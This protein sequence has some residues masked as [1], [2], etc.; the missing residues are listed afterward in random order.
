MK[1]KIQFVE[2]LGNNSINAKTPQS[3]NCITALLKVLSALL[4]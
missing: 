4:K 3:S 1:S 2:I